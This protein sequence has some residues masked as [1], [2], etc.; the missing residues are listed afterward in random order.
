[1]SYIFSEHRES[2]MKSKKH[3]RFHSARMLKVMQAVML[4]VMF[5]LMLT[6][7]LFA[8]SA[9]SASSTH[10]TP[11]Q[12]TSTTSQGNNLRVGVRADIVGFG[13]FNEETNSYYGLEVDIAKDLAKRL[14]YDGCTFSTVEPDTRKAELVSGNLDCVLACYAITTSREESLDFSPAYYNDELRLMVENSSLINHIDDLKGHTIGT[15]LGTDAAPMLVQNLAE[16]GFTD[17]KTISANANN[18]DVQFDN[19]HLLQ[20]SSYSELS[21][22]LEVG[23]VDAACMDGCIAQAYARENRHFLDW[24]GSAQN[25]GV[26]TKKGSDLSDRIATEIQEM[27]DD[28]TIAALIDKWD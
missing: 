14:G 7:A 12:N 16:A 21:R 3:A 17:G 26:A 5:A 28:G 2:H 23:E 27:L 19:F 9:C 8:L 18:S 20:Y 6:G 22:A 13:S 24:R 15:M 10:A 11:H 4:T 25:Y 1:M